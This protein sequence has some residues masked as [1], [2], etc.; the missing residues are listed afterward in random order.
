MAFWNRDPWEKEFNSN[1]KK[2]RASLAQ[3][4]D[5]GLDL[6]ELETQMPNVSAAS[7]VPQIEIAIGANSWS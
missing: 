2:M 5:L 7:L 4:A 3:L 1:T 6:I